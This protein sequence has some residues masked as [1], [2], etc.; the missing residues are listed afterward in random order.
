MNGKLITLDGTECSGKTTQIA[1]IAHYLQAQG[2]SVYTTREPG[3]TAVG[4][5]IRN[6]FLS[7]ELKPTAETELLLIFA[8]RKQHLEQEILPRLAQGEYVISDR[9]NDATYA[10]QGYARNI[11]LN[12]IQQLEHWVQQ[13]FQ[14]QL[15]LILTLPIDIAEQRL[16]RRG[17][18]KDRMEAENR[19]F[20]QRVAD[21]YQARVATQAHVHSIDASGT[22]DA[23]FN[24]I[25]PYLDQL[26]QS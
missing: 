25:R 24:H 19:A 22:P 11:P 10:Y 5:A 1:N 16:A 14:P 20:F 6:I 3:G 2:K 13:D 8:A 17:H 4:E 7:P 15:S 23:V 18:S 21:G 12:R 26:L 9:F